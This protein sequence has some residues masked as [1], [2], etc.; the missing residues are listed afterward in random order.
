M[1][2]ALLQ[3]NPTVGDLAGNATSVLTAWRRAAARGADL[4]LTT[5]LALTGYPPKDLLLY[6]GFVR[7]AEAEAQHLAALGADL[8]PL[9]LGTVVPNPAPGRPLWNAAL[10]LVG[11]SVVRTFGKTLL[12]TYDVFDEDRYFEP[13]RGDRLLALG[14][15]RLAVTICED[16]WTGPHSPVAHRYHTDPLVEIASQQPHILLNLSASP[17]VLGKQGLRE[18]MLANIARRHQTHICY[19]NQAGGN[20]DLVFDGRSSFHGPDGRLLAR[21]AAFATDIVICDTAATVTHLA[22]DDFSAPAETWRALVA[23]TRDYVRKS[24][25]HQVL[26]GLSGGVDSALTATVAVHALGADNVLGVLMPSP[27]SSQGSLDDSRELARRLGIRTHTL[28]IA[29]LMAAYDTTLAPVLESR[30]RDV[31]EENLQARIRGNLLMALSNKFGAMLLTT[32][33]KSELAVGYC[34]IYGDMNGGF[35]VLSDVPKTLVYAVSRHVN[36]TLGDPIPAAILTKA[37]SAELRPGQTD[38]DSLPP[39][40]LLDEILRRHI[41]EYQGQEEMVAAGFEPQVVARVLALIKGAE[42]KRWQAAPG[43]KIS[44]RAFGGGWRMPLACKRPL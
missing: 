36:A 26:L 34:T 10:L 33:N 42:F 43:I 5:E 25:F 40:E 32:G 2:I 19:A 21:G 44:R 15:Y 13:F 39:Y 28:A 38:Q 14:G 18:A 27:F 16:V 6:S 37:P 30:P 22:E 35:A 9:L 24:G 7:R 3:L 17:F 20:D 23:G 29:D 41:E 31:T 11:G 8:P 12:P 4:A 1:K